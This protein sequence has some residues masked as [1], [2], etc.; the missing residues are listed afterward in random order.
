MKSAPS[1]VTSIGRCADDWHVSRTT[2]APT[3]WAAW[4]IGS[5]GV[6][7]PVTLDACV[8]ATTFVFG[9]MTAGATWLT[10]RPKKNAPAVE[11]GNA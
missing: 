2:S 7:A 6:I 4:M 1:V 5:I 3:L 9:V 11:G 8:T 10:T